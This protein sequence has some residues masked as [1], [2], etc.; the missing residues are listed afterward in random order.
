MRVIDHPTM[1]KDGSGWGAMAGVS[2]ALLARG[3]FTGSPAA[4]V[5]GGDVADL[6][7]DLGTRWRVTEQYV[8]PYPVCRWAQPAIAAALALRA[9]HGFVADAIEAVSI[10]TFAAAARLDARAPATTEEAQYSLAFPVAAALVRG[11]VGVAE[12]EGTGLAD[13]EVLRLARRVEVRVDPAHD[14]L[15]PAERWSDVT[16][17]LADG[18]T[19]ASGRMAAPG[20]PESPLDGAALEAK[21]RALAEPALGER[22]AR[23]LVETVGG[24]GG[25]PSLER[26]AALVYPRPGS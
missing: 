2:A 8:K 25:G 17:S 18:R 10:G 21:F 16:V 7:E 22:R 4:T 1:L 6:W 13:P 5:E 26:L 24:L 14:A 9:G 20:D 11:R 19:L 12:I 15:F 23:R 3:G